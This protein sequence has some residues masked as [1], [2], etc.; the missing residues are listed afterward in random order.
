[1]KRQPNKRT[2]GAF[3]LAG[4]GTF[5]V[6]V[7]IAL[8]IGMR[9]NQHDLYV[10]YFH[11]SIK[12]LSVGA[13]VVL[14]GV[15]VGKVVKIEIVP[16]ANTYEFTI[17]VYVVFNNISKSIS[18]AA[19][20]HKWDEDKMVNALIERGLYGQLTN[21]SIL[22]GQLMIELNVKPS[23]GRMTLMHDED[24]PI[25]EI[26]T[27]LSSLGELSANVSDMPLREVVDNLNQTLVEFKDVLTPAVRVS[28][29]L[30][31][32]SGATINNF[33]AAVDDISRAA[34]A[35]RNLADYLERHPESLIKGK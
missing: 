19:D 17:P 30:A 9:R 20:G 4:I 24:G 21:Q 10:M 16:D 2:I 34:K 26:P 28:R 25:R 18:A 12:G 29:D 7:A 11:E 13:P 35:I 33:N 3:I 6:I 27:A 23:R 31:N 8:G 15:E 32:K 14:N 1:M 5:L 22:T